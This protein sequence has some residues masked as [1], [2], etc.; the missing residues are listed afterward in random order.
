LEGKAVN[1]LPI[2]GH[3]FPL[4]TLSDELSALNVAPTT[5]AANAKIESAR[6]TQQKDRIERSRSEWRGPYVQNVQQL[7]WKEFALFI[8]DDHWSRKPMLT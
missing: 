6:A 4:L 1:N 3:V 2:L 8:D 7:A 5:E